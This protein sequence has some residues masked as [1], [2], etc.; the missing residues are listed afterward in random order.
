MVAFYY[1][2]FRLPWWFVI[3]K[4]VDS[5]TRELKK[6]I[7]PFFIKNSIDQLKVDSL[8]N[9]G[10]VVQHRKRNHC[11]EATIAQANS[12]WSAVLPLTF[13][14]PLKILTEDID[15]SS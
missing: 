12:T 6:G 11:L 2:M 5:K 9:R 3:R 1:E 13:I 10:L 14:L 4:I 8:M 7:L 15:S